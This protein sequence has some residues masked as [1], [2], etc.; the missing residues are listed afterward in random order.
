M[1]VEMLEIGGT[2]DH[3]HVLVRIPPTVNVAQVVKQVK[4]SSS[5]LVTHRVEGGAGFK[6]Q[7][8]YGAFSVSRWDV[9]KIRHYIQN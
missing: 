3:V 7:G 5:H 8:C 9:P 4:G 2:E 1:K 6:W